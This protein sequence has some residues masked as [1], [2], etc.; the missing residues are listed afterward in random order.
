[1][2]ISPPPRGQEHRLVLHCWSDQ[3]SRQWTLDIAERVVAV[4]LGLSAAG[5]V[6]S[7]ISHVRTNTVIDDSTGLAR[8]AMA[9]RVFSASG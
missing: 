5:L 9:I 4:A 8:A 1:M 3:P 6:L 7:H 2:V